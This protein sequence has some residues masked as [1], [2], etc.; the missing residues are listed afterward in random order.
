MASSQSKTNFKYTEEDTYASIDPLAVLALIG[1]FISM[2]SA[3]FSA[4]FIVFG[5]LGVIFGLSSLFRIQRSDGTLSGFWVATIGI[6]LAVLFVTAYVTHAT[7]RDSRICDQSRDFAES[8]I[9][10]IQTGKLNEAHQLT[11]GFFSRVLPGTD[12]EKHYS[13]QKKLRID[14]SPGNTEAM[15]DLSGTPYEQRNDFFAQPSM[16]LIRD[17]GTDCQVEFVRHLDRFRKG[18][19][20]D[21]VTHEFKLTYNEDGS[22]KTHFFTVTMIREHYPGKYGAHWAVD[23][24]DDE[25][26]KVDRTRKRD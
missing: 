25:L 16:K 12:L 9:E 2:L 22:P 21:Y 4:I 18:N 3:I 14:D 8:W 11:V 24:I 13:S 17:H 6:G 15:T 26:V 19:L 20:I 5:V 7:A 23:M 10:M 1:G